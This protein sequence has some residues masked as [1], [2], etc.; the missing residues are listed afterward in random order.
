MLRMNGK[1]CF[2]SKIVSYF[3]LFNSSSGFEL[4]FFIAVG[5]LV[6]KGFFNILSINYGFCILILLLSIFCSISL[7][8]ILISLEHFLNK[9]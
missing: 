3:S 2:L 4:T 8:V 6:Y 7:Y 1:T 5:L 9:V